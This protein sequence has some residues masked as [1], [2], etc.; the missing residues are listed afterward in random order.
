LHGQTQLA[1]WDQSVLW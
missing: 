1:M